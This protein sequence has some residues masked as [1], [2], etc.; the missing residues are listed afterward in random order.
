MD[1]V[2]G[3]FRGVMSD[4]DRMTKDGVTDLGTMSF[5]QFKP[6]GT[7]VSSCHPNCCSVALQH[8]MSCCALLCLAVLCCAWP[9]LCCAAPCCAVLCCAVLCC[10][11][12][13]CGISCHPYSIRVLS[14]HTS[15][16]DVF[17]KTGALKGVVLLLLSGLV[18]Q[19][20]GQQ[21]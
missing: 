21:M 18:S 9:V 20:T 17:R 10:A 7:T 12:L 14:V 8:P 16:H 19:I 2:K 5:Q 13:C 1:G 3:T 4:I 15:M 6:V 11:V